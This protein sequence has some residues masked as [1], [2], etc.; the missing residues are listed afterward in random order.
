MGVGRGGE[1][2]GCER[3]HRGGGRVGG[4]TVCVCVCVCVCVRV[5]GGHTLNTTG[6]HR[7]GPSLIHIPLMP[8]GNLLDRH[9]LPT[10]TRTH[11]QRLARYPHNAP[12]R[13]LF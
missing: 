11:T 13:S 1:G 8:V 9:T 3:E 5:E 6:Y 7:G 2:V 4:R 10:H 12:A